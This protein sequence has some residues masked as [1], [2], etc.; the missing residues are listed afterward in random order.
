MIERAILSSNLTPLWTP[1]DTL[2]DI[3]ATCESL[4]GFT[5]EMTSLKAEITDLRKYVDYFN[6]TYFTS[7]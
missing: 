4:H 1:I 2:M 7:L 3:L 5:S 6:S